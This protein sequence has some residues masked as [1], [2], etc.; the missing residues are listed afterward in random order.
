LT[1]TKLSQKWQI[2]DLELLD[3]QNGLSNILSGYIEFV[4]VIPYFSMFKETDF[5]F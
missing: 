4:R 3:Y 2:W 5:A 1:S